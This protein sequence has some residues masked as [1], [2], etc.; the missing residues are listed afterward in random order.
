MYWD[1]KES[2][3]QGQKSRHHLYSTWVL[4]HYFK[5]KHMGPSA[6]IRSF[7]EELI[8]FSKAAFLCNFK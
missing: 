1:G 7:L 2:F 8:I 5:E 6:Q 3:K 4:R